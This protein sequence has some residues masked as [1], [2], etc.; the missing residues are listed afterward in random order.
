MPVAKLLYHLPEEQSEFDDA[1][2]GTKY[3]IQLDDVWDECFRPNFKH[4]YNEQIEKIIAKCG[5][6]NAY[7]LIEEL[8]K[9]YTTITK[10]E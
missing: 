4:G 5:N 2:N 1:V 6:D 7:N 8:S 3:S 10:E 9:I